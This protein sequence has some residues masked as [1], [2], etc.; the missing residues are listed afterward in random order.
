MLGLGVRVCLKDSGFRI[1]LV[2]GGGVRGR[3][4]GVDDARCRERGGE[5]PLVPRGPRGRDGGPA[6]KPHASEMKKG[7]L[8]Q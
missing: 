5:P 3:L 1:H 4:F 6:G 7:A 8:W 2:N